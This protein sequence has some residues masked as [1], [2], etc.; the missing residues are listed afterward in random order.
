MR[1]I[2]AACDK[3]KQDHGINCEIIDLRTLMPWDYKTV[4]ESVL[5][6]GRLVVSHEAPVTSGFGAEIL[7][8]VQD[9]C[10]YRMEAPLKRVCGFDT[11][12]PLAFEKV[13][14]P[15]MLRTYDAIVESVKP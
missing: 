3:A 2:Q 13:Y 10:F 8:T 6:T 11:P 1:V 5:K 15:D 9:K 7:A 4:C 12:F 14:L